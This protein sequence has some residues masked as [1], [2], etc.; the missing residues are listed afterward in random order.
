MANDPI[1]GP[2]PEPGREPAPYWTLTLPQVTA[3]LA[4]EPEN[5]T[6]RRLWWEMTGETGRDGSITMPPRRRP[7]SG[8]AE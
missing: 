2:W 1:R 4:R 6:Y 3:A 5:L 8:G 7:F